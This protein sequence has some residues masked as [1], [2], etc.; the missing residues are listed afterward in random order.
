MQVNSTVIKFH[1][2]QNT[3][4]D[5]KYGQQQR[6]FIVVGTATQRG[7]CTVCGGEVALTPEKKG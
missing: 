3:Y 4:Q 2:C 1:G 5:E 7:R 6:V